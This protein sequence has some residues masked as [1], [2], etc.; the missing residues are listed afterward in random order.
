MAKAKS[1]FKAG[2][3]AQ[4]AQ[5]KVVEGVPQ[6]KGIAMGGKTND[7]GR[8]GVIVQNEDGNFQRKK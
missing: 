4:M 7:G 6:R 5:G 1:P 2:R 8:R 3:P